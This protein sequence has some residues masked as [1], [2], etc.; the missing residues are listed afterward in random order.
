MTPPIARP[1]AITEEQL[2]EMPSTVTTVLSTLPE[3]RMASVA[4]IQRGDYSQLIVEG[5]REP[6]GALHYF[7][8]DTRLPAR[9]EEA[10]ADPSRL[11]PS[12]RL[13][14]DFGSASVI[15]IYYGDYDGDASNDMILRLSD[16]GLRLIGTAD[17]SLPEPIIVET[18]PSGPP[19]YDPE[20]TPSASGG[21]NR[22]IENAGQPS[23]PSGAS[24]T[25]SPS[26]RISNSA[27]M[28]I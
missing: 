15:Q 14:L 3:G 26:Q 11:D 8:R 7:L 9:R 23:A 1:I 16:G 27:R 20:P 4:T 18:A 13:Y 2:A 22:R 10:D 25:T 28:G 24:S 12:S 19:P 17:E 5:Y 21:Q 6:T